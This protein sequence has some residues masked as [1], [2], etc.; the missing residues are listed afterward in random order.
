MIAIGL[1]HELNIHLCPKPSITKIFS[2]DNN[3]YAYVDLTDQAPKMKKIIE[4]IQNK[5]VVLDAVPAYSM[6][7][8]ESNPVNRNR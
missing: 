3:T 5:V 2:Y 8:T 7:S 4:P 1:D 6:P